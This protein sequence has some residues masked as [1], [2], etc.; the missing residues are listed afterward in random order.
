M[1]SGPNF[2]HWV[3]QGDCI[4]WLRLLPDNSVDAVVSDPPYGL[5]DPPD[6]HEVMRAWLAGEEYLATGGGFMGR[7]WDAF[8]PGPEV[9]RECYRVLKP[10]GHIVAF[11]STRTVDWLGMALRFSGFEVRDTI[12]W[13]YWNGFPKGTLDVGKKID[14]R[15]GAEREVVG[16][17]HRVVRNDGATP[18]VPTSVGAYDITAPATDEAKRWTGW[19]SLLK[20][21]QEPA[22]LARKP[23]SESSSVENLLRWGTGYLN[24]D[25]C[26]FAEGAPEWPGTNGK[27]QPL[28]FEGNRG[29]GKGSGNGAEIYGYR[30][31]TDFDPH[32]AGP[33]PRQR[34]RG[35]E[36]W[37]KGEG[38]WY[39]GPPM[40]DRGRGGNQG[41]GPGTVE[42][43]LGGRGEEEAASEGEKQPPD[44]EASPAHALACAA[45]DSTR[46]AGD[47]SVPRFRDH[48]H[49]RHVG[50]DAVRGLRALRSIPP[51]RRVTDAACPREPRRLAGHQTGEP[52]AMVA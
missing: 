52:Q 4:Q 35:T 15:A 6:V 22:I 2:R 47:R 24:A 9:W 37:T 18:I 48:G 43:G 32:G 13:L 27:L 12:S 3:Y 26:R 20:P 8:I 41:R 29:S 36:A 30:E 38:P 49:R 46:R 40:G 14:E 5:G 34:A 39:R 10:G 33:V 11:S 16:Q 31:K 51:D 28:S 1:A 17:G 44:R 50:G 42:P 45:S 7:V 21:C 25:A 23:I 19:S